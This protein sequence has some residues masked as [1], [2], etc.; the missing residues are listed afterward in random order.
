MSCNIYLQNYK[1]IIIYNKYVYIQKKKIYNKELS[2]IQYTFKHKK[3]KYKQIN[4][5]KKNII[6]I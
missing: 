1:N 4:K 2:S 5:T 3:I 6:F